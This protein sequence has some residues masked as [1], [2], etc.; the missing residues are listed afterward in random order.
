MPSDEV[1]VLAGEKNGKPKMELAKARYMETSGRFHL[2][3]PVPASTSTLA[4]KTKHKTD[5]EL[6]SLGGRAVRPWTCLGTP[7]PTD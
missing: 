3:I 6:R 5:S 2:R 4:Y 1:V 7:P